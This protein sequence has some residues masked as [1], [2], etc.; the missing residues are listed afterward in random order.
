MRAEETEHRVLE[1]DEQRLADRAG[2]NAALF[3]E[4]RAATSTVRAI[5]SSG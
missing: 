2:R 1:L 4:R 3:G 5:E